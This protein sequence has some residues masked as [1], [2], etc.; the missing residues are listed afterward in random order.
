MLVG[1]DEEPSIG[2]GDGGPDPLAQLVSGEDLEAG[3][4]LHDETAPSIVGGVET[5]AAEHTSNL[6]LSRQTLLGI[7][8]PLPKRNNTRYS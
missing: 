1:P 4:G 6:S 5:V 8:T 7:S 2:D 3:R